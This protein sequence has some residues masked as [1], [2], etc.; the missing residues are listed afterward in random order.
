MR[1][2]MN[3]IVQ[4]EP[5][6]GAICLLVKGEVDLANASELQ[7]HLNAVVRAEENLIVDMSNLRYLDSSGIKVL[8]EAHQQFTAIKRRMVLAAAV[9]TV[10]KVLNI[11]G[12]DQLI[13]MFP[14]VEEA[15]NNIRI[16]NDPQL[17]LAGA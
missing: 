14:T 7:A 10:Q 6:T 8:L 3:L 9:V 17:P 15:L 5:R 4:R 13:S 16:G 12:I 1:P 2:P 11:T